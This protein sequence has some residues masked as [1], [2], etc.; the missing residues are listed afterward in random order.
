M[1]SLNFGNHQVSQLI[2]TRVGTTITP[3]A[4]TAAYTGTTKTFD[5]GGWS[6]M[7]LDIY[8]TP[9]ATETNNTCSVKLEA[10]TDGVNFAQLT[11]ESATTGVSTLY[12][13]EFLFT[14]ASASTLYAFTLG[15]DIFYKKVRVSLQEGGV[16]TNF[17]TAF[18]EA[19]LSG[20]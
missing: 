6:K 15:I 2:G 18:V 8:Y 16:V 19:T 11:N 1:G 17:G 10:S 3:V 5:V 4:L 7:N 20:Q 14:G 12:Q 13:R 9:G